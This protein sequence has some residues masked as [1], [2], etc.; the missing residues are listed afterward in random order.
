MKKRDIIREL[1]QLG[2]L[3]RNTKIPTQYVLQ[4]ENDKYMVFII[5]TTSTVQVGINSPK[6][7][8]IS[9]GRL[10]G[11]KY[12]KTSSLLYRWDNKEQKVLIVLLDTPYRILKYINENELV[13][14]SEEKQ[15][16]NIQ[17]IRLI[18]EIQSI[19]K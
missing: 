4:T 3:K 17:F 8:E 16:H 15:V 14:I 11:I 10:Y 6:V 5:K 18:N 9:K 7:I 12:K 13:D 19:V 2:K 1:K